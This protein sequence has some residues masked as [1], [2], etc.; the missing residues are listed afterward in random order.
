MKKLTKSS[1]KK[2]AGVLGGIAHY[3]DL[4]PTIVRVFYV[5]LFIFSCGIPA[6]LFYIIAAIVMPNSSDSPVVSH[7]AH[8]ADSEHTSRNQ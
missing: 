1:D 2:I 4:D 6:L 7:E 3:F 5:F 8:H